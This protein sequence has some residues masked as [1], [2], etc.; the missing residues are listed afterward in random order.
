[1]GP[2]CNVE[3]VQRLMGCL[4]ALSR[5]VSRLGE[6]GMPLYKLL[7]KTDSFQWTEE[8]QKALDQLK[9]F[10]TSPPVLASPEPEEPLLLYVAATTHTISTALVVERAEPG[11]TQKVQRPM[12]FVSKV[13]SNCETRYTHVQKLLYA[14]LI[15]KRK[16]LHYFESH[17]ISVVTSYG[18]G[19]IVNNRDSSSKIAKWALEHM[20]FDISYVPRLAIK[21]QA[22][23]D[24]VAEWTEVQVALTPVVCEYW[25]M[26]FDGSLTLNRARSGVVPVSPKGDRLQYTLRLHFKATNNVT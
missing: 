24:F 6:R 25:T 3:G 1:M 9:A 15:T 7:R 17:P 18:L 22:L 20:G 4:A 12:Y 21:S 23:A 10:L 19:E 8:A 14:V 16:L 11:H 5:F 2:I 13:L 26:Y